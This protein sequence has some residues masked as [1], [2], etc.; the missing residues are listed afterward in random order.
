MGAGDPNLPVIRPE[1]PAYVLDFYVDGLGNMPARDWLR[2]LELRKRFAAGH[3]MQTQLQQ[4]G[5]AVCRTRWG[6]NLGSG[7]AEF[8]LSEPSPEGEVLLRV[9][10]HA[11]VDRR[12]LILHSYDKGDDPS[13]ASAA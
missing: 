1:A 4:D 8:R 3:A 6:K 11:F 13:E 9:F 10:F 7:L 2:S 12:I 5:L